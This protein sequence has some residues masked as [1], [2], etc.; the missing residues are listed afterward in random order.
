MS[1]HFVM[2][3]VPP[4]RCCWQLC[5]SVHHKLL[6]KWFQA[7]IWWLRCTWSTEWKRQVQEAIIFQSNAFAVKV[8]ASSKRDSILVIHM[9]LIRL[10]QTNFNPLGRLSPS[11]Q[12]FSTWWTLTV[13]HLLALMRN[14]PD[15]A[16]ACIIP[17]S[18]SQ[19]RRNR[20]CLG[21]TGTVC[22]GKKRRNNERLNLL[23]HIIHSLPH[24]WRGACCIVLYVWR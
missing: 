23:Q 1:N 18:T 12:S 4:T 13:L 16:A 3:Q 19:L 22:A 11:I 15:S 17:I 8:D 21:N 24:V 2:K 6:A 14:S 10:C 20:C 5:S 9:R 7:T